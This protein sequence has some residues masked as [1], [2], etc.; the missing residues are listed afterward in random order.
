[1]PYSSGFSKGGVDNDRTS[2]IDSANS[3][4]MDLIIASAAKAA[5]YE[6]GFGITGC[7]LTE[8]GWW[9]AYAPEHR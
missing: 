1:M 5:G 9:A 4:E 8:D 6:Q 2:A 3:D 7:D